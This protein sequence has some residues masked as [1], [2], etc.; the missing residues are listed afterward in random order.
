M[1]KCA[2]LA[3][4]AAIIIQVALSYCASCGIGEKG[5]PCL[6]IGRD[7]SIRAASLVGKR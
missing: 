5:V 4:P 3:G 7:E 6:G 1:G 2:Y